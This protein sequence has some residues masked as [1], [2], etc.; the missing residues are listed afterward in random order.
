VANL[1]NYPK[2]WENWVISELAKQNIQTGAKKNL[3]FWRSRS[4]SEIDLIVKG[5]EK[6]SAYEIKWSGQKVKDRAF[7]QRYQ[8]QVR[9]I[10]SLRPLVELE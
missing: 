9:V 5:G 4:G 3:Y 6:I 2:L 7:R 1:G 8:T 10:D